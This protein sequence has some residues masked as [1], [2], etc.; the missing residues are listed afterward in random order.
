L[1]VP[2][3]AFEFFYTLLLSQALLQIMKVVIPFKM[4]N[5]G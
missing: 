2:K 5:L 3:I 4:H 1:D